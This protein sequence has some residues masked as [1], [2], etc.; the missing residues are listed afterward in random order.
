MQIEQEQFFCA[1]LA[2]EDEEPL[3]GT[4]TQVKVWLLLEYRDPWAAKAV[5]DNSLAP[6]VQ[7]HLDEQVA[8]IPG[9]RLLFI[10]QQKPAHTGRRFFLVRT[11][12]AAPSL[13]EFEL[14]RYKDLLALDL[15]AVA[16][17]SPAYSDHLRDDP[18][19]LVCTN[20]KR[21]KCCAKFGLPMVKALLAN[22][23]ENVWQSTHIGGHRYAPNTLFLPHSVNYGHLAPDQIRP[24]VEAYEEG[25]LYDLDNYRGRTYYAPAVQAADTYLRRELNLLDLTAVRL[26]TASME[27]GDLWRVSFYL[28]DAGEEHEILLQISES[29]RPFPVSCTSPAMKP[30]SHYRLVEQ[31]LVSSS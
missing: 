27:A 9:S 6:A 1:Q 31:R 2:R 21:D 12:E 23:I 24:A 28:P 16:A 13:Y 15:T 22:G 4:A 19:F 30:V 8:A 7:S 5:K 11:D 25:R 20:G 17:G 29:E 10:K 26:Q 18:L 3:L 14:H